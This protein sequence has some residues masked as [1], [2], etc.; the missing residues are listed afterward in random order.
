MAEFCKIKADG[1]VMDAPN[2]LR[3][4]VTNPSD[5]RYR[6]EGYLEMRYTEPPEYNSNTQYVTDYW[7][8]DGVYAVQRWEVHEQEKNSSDE[9]TAEE[10]I[11]I[12]L[13]VVENEKE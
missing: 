3:I 9:I 4:V 7:V 12:L 2:P 11:N 10:A 8:Q 1:T 6:S 5:E 13:G